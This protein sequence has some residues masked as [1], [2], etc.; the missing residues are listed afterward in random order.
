MKYSKFYFFLLNFAISF[1]AVTAQTTINGNQNFEWNEKE[2]ILNPVTNEKQTIWSFQDAAIN[3]DQVELS[4]FTKRFEVN[5][6]GKIKM[7]FKNIVSEPVELSEEAKLTLAPEPIIQSNIHQNRNDYYGHVSFSPFI[8]KPNG[9]AHKILSFEYEILVFETP[10]Q[11]SLTPENTFNSVLETG[12]IF[13]IAVAETGIHQIDATFLSNELNINL[14]DVDPKKIQLF[15]NLGGSLHETIAYPRADDLTENSILVLGEGDGSFDAGDKIIFYGEGPN[16]WYHDKLTDDY[17]Y[18]K[19]IYDDYN[20]YF[21]KINQAEGLRVSENPTLDESQF[22]TNE[23]HH[24]Q[25]YEQDLLNLLGRFESGHGSGQLWFGDNLSNNRDLDATSKFDFTNTIP[26]ENMKVKA[27]F[28]GRCDITSKVQLNVGNETYSK[29]ISGI[30]I[31]K[32]EST[33]ARL[34]NFNEELLPVSGGTP[35]SINFPE[36][37]G[38]QSEGWLDFIQ[39]ETKDLVQYNSSPLHF[40]NREAEDYQSTSF[41]LENLN[42]NVIIWNI[43]ERTNPFKQSYVLNGTTGTF[44]YNSENFNEFL[45][46]E[47]NQNHL[48]PTAIGPVENQNIHGLQN[49]SFVIIYHPEFEDAALELAE[50]RANHNGEN[51]GTVNILKL[52]NEFSSG[53]VDPTAIRDFS[54]M[55]LERGTN[56]K[57]LLLFGDG[58]YDYRHV[59]KSHDDQNFVPVYETKES[60]YP[61][62]AFPTDDYYALLS[63]QEGDDLKGELDIAVG[64]LPARTLTEANQLVQKI[65]RY[66]TDPETLGDW[67][68]RIGFAGDD[69]DSNTHVN[70]V[71]KVASNV[72]TNHQVFNQEK[73]YFDAY[74]EEATPGGER[75]PDANSAINNNM[76]RGLLTFC[77]L[78]HGGPTGLSQERVVKVSDIQSWEQSEKMPLMVTATCSFT[79]YDDPKMTSAGEHAILKPDGGMIALYSTVRAVFAN[80]NYRL[81]NAVFDTIYKKQD[82]EYMSIGEILQNSKNANSEDTLRVNARKFALIG[83]PSMRLA[84]PEFDVVTTKINGK[85][86]DVN[87]L[88]TI[89]ALQ[90]V[91]VEGFVADANGQIME[92][93]NGVLF[94]SIFDKEIIIQ[95][96]ANN[97]GSNVK[98][99]PIQKSVLFKG[100]ASITN[101]KFKF[102]FIVPKDINYAYGKGKIS[103]YATDGISKDASGYSKDLI[104]GSTNEN[105]LTDDQGPE[106]NLFMND[107]NFVYGGITNENPLLIAK[108]TDDYGINVTG[109]SVGHDLTGVIDDA[110]NESIIL[111]DF[112]EAE[113]D[114]FRKGE[115]RYPLSDLEP[116]LHTINVKAWDISNNSAEAR[117]EF[118]VADDAKNA[119]ERVLNYPNPFSTNTCFQFEH[120]LAGADLDILIYIYTVSGRLVKTIEHQESALGFRVNNIKWDGT[121]DFGGKL[122][123]GVYLY[124]IKVKTNQ[125]GITKESGFEK[126]VILK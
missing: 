47:L 115:V 48:V 54:R 98:N 108:L 37:P 78:G 126:M 8:L 83:D 32:I 93:F 15:G 33:Y 118:I 22:Q 10:T 106:I 11:Q 38:Y 121:D 89:K 2:I 36:V 85:D 50:H 88:D 92:D 66:D 21:L 40:F 104:I 57:Y 6:Y 81:T 52:Y 28:A 35:I 12:Q 122:A 13:K 41:I 70:D 24:F 95:T 1:T 99:F 75:Y 111:N 34:A 124:K 9:E 105:G 26:T 44:S 71:E 55:I 90:E 59:N 23:H 39:V 117:T 53:R 74:V 73:I 19:N 58:S 29:N 113:L 80:E 31:S 46:F 25:R 87:S 114:D 62:D 16:T 4:F 69:E 65:I 61:I 112:Y 120:D 14:S 110:G 101:G 42:A 64:R 51:V 30:N 43:A 60:L 7:Y 5:G 76:F 56:F 17:T 119:L 20:Y 107:E 97:S 49:V 18:N 84:L 27:S 3:P 91:E 109:T 68:L 72:R 123:N 45:A 79:G 63:D 116:G 67:R 86:I 125:L 96:L 103:Y 82:G 94:P 77:Y 100:K 102:S